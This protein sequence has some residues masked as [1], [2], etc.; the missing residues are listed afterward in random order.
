MA[1]A[2]MIGLMR[3]G[4]GFMISTTTEAIDAHCARR[5]RYRIAAKKPCGSAPRGTQKV[6]TPIYRNGSDGR[7]SRL[8]LMPLGAGIRERC[9]R[10]RSPPGPRRRKAARF[11]RARRA[12]LPARAPDCAI[13]RQQWSPYNVKML[14]LVPDH[15]ST[16]SA[17]TC[18]CFLGRNRQNPHFRT[19][20]HT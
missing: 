13:R 2:P 16:L 20:I 4:A 15:D 1:N 3:T 9:A 19:K 5:K 8:A 11:T 17:H 12:G 10:D 14:G 7:P 6:W 18:A